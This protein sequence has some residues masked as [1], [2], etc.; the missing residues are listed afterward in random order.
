LNP[1]LQQGVFYMTEFLVS[2]KMITYNHAPYIAQAIEG[3]LEQ[4]TN[5]PFEL[6]IGED[7]STDG[8]R[9]IVFEYQKKYPDV[10]RVITSESNVGMKRNGYRT[11]KVC[12]GEYIAFCEGD[13]YWHDP[14]KLQKQVDYL[15]SHPGC[16]LVYSDYDVYHIDSGKR[17]GDFIKY[18]K[19]DIP[20][21]PGISDFVENKGEICI[22][23][24]TCTVMIRRSLYEQIIESDPLLHQSDHFSM[25][26]TQL[27]AE[28]TT[29]A[30]LHYIPESTATHIITGESAT[31]SKD[32]KKSLRFVIST[33]EL[34]LYLCKK[35]N[36]PSTARDKPEAKWCDYSLRLAFHARSPE[37]AD[38]VRKKKQTFT[39]KEWL[40]YYGA[41]HVAVYYGCRVTASFLALF[42]KGH[43]Q[44]L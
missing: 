25:G 18:R 17:I 35:Y 44:W 26:D 13:D 38:E 6:V 20:K 36:L 7:C 23:I 22:G 3:V 11:T 32:I 19:W 33:A 37:L 27:W 5:F 15:E 1:A 24:L 21:N 4:Q 40:R 8:T 30:D 43:D 34:S 31:R 42:K 14:S 12:R 16:G 10:I 2:V 9:E 29:T 39:W 28:V 41:K